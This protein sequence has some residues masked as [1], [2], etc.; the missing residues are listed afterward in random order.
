MTRELR[1]SI[2]IGASR[3]A[4]TALAKANRSPAG[5]PPREWMC[6]TS[7]RAESTE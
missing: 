3:S 5:P 6:P 2:V 4:L 1:S 7:F